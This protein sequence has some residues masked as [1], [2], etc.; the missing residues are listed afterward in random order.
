L[1]LGVLYQLAKNPEK[2]EKLREEIMKILPEKNSTLNSESLKNIPY[3]RAC[4]KETLRVVPVITGNM[5]GIGQDL[6]IKGYQVPKGTNVAMSNALLQTEDDHFPKSD[7]FLPERWL[8]NSDS[9]QNAECP[10]SKTAHPFVYLPFGFGSRTCI[11]RRFSEMEVEV[12]IAR[13]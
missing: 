4:L 5:R 8:K 7:Q 6:V 1:T 11:G 2:Q 3:L 10:H 12:L 9:V 13:Y